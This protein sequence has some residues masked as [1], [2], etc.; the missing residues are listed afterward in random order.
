VNVPRASGIK[1]RIARKEGYF[2][3]IKISLGICDGDGSSTTQ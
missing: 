1:G 3:P 2:K